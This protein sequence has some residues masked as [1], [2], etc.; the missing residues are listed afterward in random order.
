M[1]TIFFLIGLAIT[2]AAQAQ[3]TKG[4]LDMLLKNMANGKSAPISAAEIAEKLQN[5]K[6]IVQ[7]VGTED[8]AKAF[9]SQLETAKSLQTESGEIRRATVQLQEE[10]KESKR[11]ADIREKNATEEMRS[12]EYE[13]QEAEKKKNPRRDANKLPS[14]LD[15]NRCAG[16]RGC[17]VTK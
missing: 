12:M 4:E 14:K 8:E 15:P 5:S 13:R 2:S 16:I 10:S 1:K 3:D 17:T 7:K 9:N 6:E 11:L